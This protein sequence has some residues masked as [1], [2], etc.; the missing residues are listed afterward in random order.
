[1]SLFSPVLYATLAI[2]ILL[3]ILGRRCRT[4]L[5]KT[6]RPW[7]ESAIRSRTPRPTLEWTS[8]QRTWSKRPYSGQPRL[9]A[10]TRRGFLIAERRPRNESPVNPRYRGLY[11]MP[12]WSQAAYEAGFEDPYV[13]SDSVDELSL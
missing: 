12:P 4:N 8:H 2:V 7:L 9:Q 5:A 3:A 10:M 11:R 6:R 13:F 1:M